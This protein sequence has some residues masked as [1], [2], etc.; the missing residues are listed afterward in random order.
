MIIHDGLRR[1]V[2]VCLAP[3]HS[4]ASTVACVLC[5]N[6]SIISTHT[7]THRERYYIYE[8]ITEKLLK[9]KLR[10][11]WTRCSALCVYNACHAEISEYILCSSALCVQWARIKRT[12]EIESFN[13]AYERCTN[14]PGWICFQINTHT[15]TLNSI[16][17]LISTIYFM[18]MKEKK[19]KVKKKNVQH[20]RNATYPMR[21]RMV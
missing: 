4:F 19:W 10:A 21:A 9:S 14:S 8:L 15:H 17:W 18:K 11:Y 1:G 12:T 6:I 3:L 7:H 5:R 13:I 16:K 2:C 20:I